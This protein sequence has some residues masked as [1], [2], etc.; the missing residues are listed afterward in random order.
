MPDPTV[1]YF[2]C[3]ERA[4]H[5]LYLPSG[6]TAWDD[7]LPADFP[8]PSRVLD[9][10]FLPPRQPE[11]E[12]RASLVH[13]NGW[14]VLA[15]WDRSVDTRGKCNSAFVARGTLDFDGIVSAA[16]VAFPK[17]WVRFKFAVQL[18]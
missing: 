13:I 5:H 17:V 9:C 14:T 18:A 6:M 8:C 4:G 16:K 12:G 11:I 7:R 15:F 1:Y 10:G 3:L 2:G